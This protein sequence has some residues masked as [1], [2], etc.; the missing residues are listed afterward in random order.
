MIRKKLCAPVPA[1]AGLHTRTTADVDFCSI[2]GGLEGYS[3]SD[4][5]LLCKEA[6]MRPVRRLMAKLDAIEAATG[7]VK[8]D[9]IKLDCVTAEDIEDAV[10]VTK[11]SARLVAH[12]YEEWQ[13]EFS[14]S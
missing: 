5:A 10:A 6:A 1:P 14:S 8:D 3:G 9:V 7:T 11:P 4:I 13:A 2:G 12:K